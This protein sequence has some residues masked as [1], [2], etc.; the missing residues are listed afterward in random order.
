V[1]SGSTY[2]L[3]N[4]KTNGGTPLGTPP[5]NKWMSA[6]DN[7]KFFA[8]ELLLAENGAINLL[9]S[10]VINLFNDNNNLVAKINGNGEG[11]YCIY[12]PGT[13]K[14]WYEMI[15]GWQ[16]YYDNDANNTELWRLGKTGVIMRPTLGV[17]T[18]I[19]LAAV[20]Q[21]DLNSFD[22]STVF[23][24][25][26]YRQYIADSGEYNGKIFTSEPSNHDPSSTANILPD[27]MYT[28]NEKPR[29][30]ASIDKGDGYDGYTLTVYNISGGFIV[31]PREVERVTA[32][33]Q[34]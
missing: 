20:T 6:G 2:Y 26:T 15:P 3:V 22:G 11:S 17:W 19:S 9:S 27:G 24:R 13:T 16:I 14:K 18:D 4:V 29:K 1:K 12:Y 10:N 32:T 33:E 7:L 30:T 25:T 5:N 23:T 34:G 21:S 8:T 28:P 31:N